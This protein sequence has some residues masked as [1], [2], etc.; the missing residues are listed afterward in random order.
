MTRTIG[1]RLTADQIKTLDALAASLSEQ[2]DGVPVS[3][4]HVL[5]KLIERGL[6]EPSQLWGSRIGTSR[7]AK[8]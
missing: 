7:K 4:S 5:R 3:R 6:A 8:T 2:A 1:V